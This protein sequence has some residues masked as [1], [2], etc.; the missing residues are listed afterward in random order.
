MTTVIS[1][2]D[3]WLRG[4]KFVEFYFGILIYL[5]RLSSVSHEL[6]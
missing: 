6:A 4:G 5:Y 3:G 2:I 1:V